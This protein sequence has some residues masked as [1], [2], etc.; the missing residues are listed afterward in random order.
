MIVRADGALVSMTE[1]HKPEDKLERARIYA[2]NGTVP[3][4]IERI[5]LRIMRDRQQAKYMGNQGIGSWK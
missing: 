5:Y 3:N 2:A 1:D 4:L